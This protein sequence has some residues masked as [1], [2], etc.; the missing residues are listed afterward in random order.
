MDN[1]TPKENTQPSEPEKPFLSIVVHSFFIIPFLIAVFCV[2]L[3]TSIRLLTKEQQTAY[4]L[5]AQVKTGGLTKRWQAAFELSKILA[6]PKQ[7]P[8]SERFVN[9]LILAFKQSEHD[10]PRVRQYLALAMGRTQ[11]PVFW[12]PLTQGIDRERGENLYAIIYTLGMLKDPR[13]VAVLQPFLSHQNARLRSAAAVSLGNIGSSEAIPLLRVAL[14]DTEA[15]VQWGAAVSLALMQDV[16]GEEVLLKLLDRNY[17][18]NFTEVDQTEQ[19]NLMLSAIEASA[20]LNS[21][22]LKQKMEYLAANDSSMKVRAAA[23]KAL[24][25]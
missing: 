20:H 19:V 8:D 3:F 24:K 9:E 18:A 4:E 6:T 10:D 17:L 22:P 5:L 25:K 1:T 23:L 15:N 21:E 12:W 7:V 11:N 13:G 16:S 14:N 2:L